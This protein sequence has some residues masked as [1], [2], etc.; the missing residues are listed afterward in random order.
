M[1]NLVISTM[2]LFTSAV[3]ALG[4]V[5]SHEEV[6]ENLFDSIQSIETCG[7]WSLNGRLG[8]FR[9]L[10]VYHAGQDMLFV[11]V[12]ALSSG[13]SELKVLHGFT[14]SE[15]NND[16]AEIG[17][18]TISCKPLTE[19]VIQIEASATNGHSGEKYKL[20]I[21]VD[22]KSKTYEYSDTITN[23]AQQ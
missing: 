16:H 18:E 3:F 14:F 7:S 4:R 20:S 5:V 11:D 1:K 9:V 19:N 17:L 8:E 13:G 10:N 6:Q 15:I 2:L 12:V 22:G 23:K 21:V